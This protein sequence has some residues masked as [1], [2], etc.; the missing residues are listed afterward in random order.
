VR[1]QEPVHLRLRD[2][3]ILHWQY[4]QFQ[5]HVLRTDS[6]RSADILVRFPRRRAHGCGQE[7]PRSCPRSAKN[8]DRCAG[9]SSSIFIPAPQAGVARP[10][11]ASTAPLWLLSS[12]T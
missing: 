1:T 4:D 3:Q 8:R 5:L 7:C 11:L 6:H 10:S 12:L 9:F 2:G